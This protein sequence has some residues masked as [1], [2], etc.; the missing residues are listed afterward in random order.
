VP[1]PSIETERMRDPLVDL[2]DVSADQVHSFVLSPGSGGMRSGRFEVL[3][4]SEEELVRVV[5]G[6]VEALGYSLVVVLGRLKG[7]AAGI[8]GA[9]RASEAHCF[10][11]ARRLLLSA[12]AL[13]TAIALGRVRMVGAIVDERDGRV[14]W[15]GEHPDQ[16]TLLRGGK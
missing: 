4:D 12:N 16:R 11:I 10:A 8:D 9:F 14:H 7:H 1:S 2:F 3:V 5:D 13:S 15:L 6:S